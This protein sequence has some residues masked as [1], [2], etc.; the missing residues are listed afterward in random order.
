MPGNALVLLQQRHKYLKFC[1]L[2][3]PGDYAQAILL[4]DTLRLLDGHVEKCWRREAQGW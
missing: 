4:P 1:L 3:R 2:L